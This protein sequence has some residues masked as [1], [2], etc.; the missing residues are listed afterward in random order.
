MPR[1]PPA[2]SVASAQTAAEQVEHYWAAL[3][4][5]VNFADY[6]TSSLAAQAAADLNKHVV[7]SQPPE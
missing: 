3:L 7:H 1:L 4:R 5:D 2:P 6:A